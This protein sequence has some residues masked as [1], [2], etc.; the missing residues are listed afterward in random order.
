MNVQL[1][2]FGQSV[3]R[4]GHCRRP[5]SLPRWAA[6]DGTQ[7]RLWSLVFVTAAL[8]NLAGGLPGYLAPSWVF[9]ALFDRALSDPLLTS[10][11]RGAWGTTFLYFVGYLIVA[12]DPE[13]HTGIVLLGT[14]G[15]VFFAINLLSLYAHG[16]ATDLVFVVVVGDSV[17]SALF[18]RYLFSMRAHRE[19]I[20]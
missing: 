1:V 17:F 12:R 3:V 6:M 15:K 2:A 18:V 14:I 9:H 19:G 20:V 13:R 8:W 16:L 4:V 7:R 10:I 11:Y 5:V